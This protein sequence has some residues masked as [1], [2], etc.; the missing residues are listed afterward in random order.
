VDLVRPTVGERRGL[1]CQS[2]P[3]ETN[4]IEDGER[5]SVVGHDVRDDPMQAHR[6]EAIPADDLERFGREA[7]TPVLATDPIADLGPPIDARPSE[8]S[9]L[10]DSLRLASQPDRERDS[11][12]ASLTAQDALNPVAAGFVP[13]PEGEVS[14]DLN[15][16]KDTVQSC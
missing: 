5:A 4:P 7:A 3:S 2:L 12:A 13:H 10:T 14:R 16:A 15:V 8:E 9:D 11:V 1:S 6:R